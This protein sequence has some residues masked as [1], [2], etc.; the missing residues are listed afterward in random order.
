[1]DSGADPS[2]PLVSPIKREDLSG[3]PAALIITAEFDPLRD[4]GELYGRRLVEAGVD[5]T[6]SLY[7][8]ANHGFVANFSWI[9]EFHR[10]IQETG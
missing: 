1:M 3:L 2:D 4:E 8:G 6:V 5:A 10:A 9:P 7:A